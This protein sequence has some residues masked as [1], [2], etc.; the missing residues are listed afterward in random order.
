MTEIK[1]ETAPFDARFPHTNQTK[2]CWQNYVDYNKCITKN[3]EDFPACQQFFKAYRSLCPAE[4]TT[5]WDE[6]KDNG[7]LPFNLKP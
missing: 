4:W 1:I 3:G 5:K 2:H 7:V 6:A